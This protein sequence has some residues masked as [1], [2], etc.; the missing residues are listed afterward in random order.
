LEEQ[1]AAIAMDLERNGWSHGRKTGEKD[2][3]K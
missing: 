1:A 3:G 2:R